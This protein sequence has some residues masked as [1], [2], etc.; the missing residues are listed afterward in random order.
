MRKGH[1]KHQTANNVMFPAFSL[2]I[3]AGL[4]TTMGLA[5]SDASAVDCSSSGT[6]SASC[7]TTVNL[8]VPSSI[9]ITGSPLA[10]FNSDNDLTPGV[11][12]SSNATVSVTT[13]SANG[14]TLSMQM[15]ESQTAGSTNTLYYTSSEYIPSI[16]KVQRQAAFE[17]NPTTGGWGFALDA[18]NYRPL[19]TVNGSTYNTLNLKRT[20]TTA[21]ADTTT[22]T[23][24]VLPPTTV[25]N[26]IY[27]NTVTVTATANDAI[28]LSSLTISG[29]PTQTQY[30]P[31]NYFNTDGLTIYA[32]YSDGKQ[33]LLTDGQYTV[34]GGNP[35]TAGQTS[36]TISYTDNGITKSGTVTGI[37]VSGSAVTETGANQGASTRTITTSPTRGFASTNN[38][39]NSDSTNSGD[40]NSNNVEPQGAIDSYDTSKS[41]NADTALLAS[42]LS[43][44]AATAT[45]GIIILVAAKRRRKDEEE[46]DDIELS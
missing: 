35:L 39:G 18:T 34:N 5:G 41:S 13:N 36:V 25:Q 37:T 31:G 29:T 1:N 33:V 19:P 9:S 10:T 45:A 7:N 38:S 27:Q 14:Y 43:V 24:G 46:E 23:F 15:S 12:Y 44:S 3:L 20:H 40:A 17:Q 28:T 30:A 16:T 26:A 22:L 32:V 21:S 4:L 11:F 42:L 2:L 8:V 6:S